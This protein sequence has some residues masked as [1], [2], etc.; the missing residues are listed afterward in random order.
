MTNVSEKPTKEELVETEYEVKEKID[1][2]TFDPVPMDKD[3]IT[4]VS[5]VRRSQ[6]YPLEK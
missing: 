6:N 4:K 2:T 1:L 3:E 5:E